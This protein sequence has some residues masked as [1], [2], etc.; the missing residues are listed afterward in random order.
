MGGLSRS[1]FRGALSHVT[2]LALRYHASDERPR[3][4]LIQITQKTPLEK[5]GQGLQTDFFPKFH[6][7]IRNQCPFF[8]G[9]A[10]CIFRLDV[11]LN[12]STFQRDTIS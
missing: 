7:I 4:C 11:E 8:P 5:V 2:V 1:A 12:M 6:L 3:E 9:L 10:A